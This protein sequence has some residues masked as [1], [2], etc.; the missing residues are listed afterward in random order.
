MVF[1]I[2]GSSR[3]VPFLPDPTTHQLAGGKSTH[4]LYNTILIMRWS[5]QQTPNYP[6]DVPVTLIPEHVSRVCESVFQAWGQSRK[7]VPGPLENSSLDLASSKTYWTTLPGVEANHSLSCILRKMI[8]SN[9]QATSC[10]KYLEG[11]ERFGGERTA[12]HLQVFLHNGISWQS[13]I[14]ALYWLSVGNKPKNK[15]RAN[16]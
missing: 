1:L 15:I 12:T 9:C 7:Q 5:G 2:Q 3:T 10:C 8:G 16:G 13:K 4:W 14:D 6:M 11:G